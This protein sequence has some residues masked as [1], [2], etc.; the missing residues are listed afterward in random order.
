MVMSQS[1]TPLLSFLGLFYC[2]EVN[3]QFI[4]CDSKVIS[5]RAKSLPRSASNAV[6]GSNKLEGCRVEIFGITSNKQ[7]QVDA[8]SKFILKKLGH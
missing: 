1:T 7:I 3:G 5:F 4:A 2:W 6:I 8:A